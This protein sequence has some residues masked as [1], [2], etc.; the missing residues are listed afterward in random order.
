LRNAIERAVILG[1]QPQIA[2]ADLP[3]EVRQSA[4]PGGPLNPSGNGGAI[5]LEQ[6]EEQHIRRVL[7]QTR[8]VAEAAEVLGIDQATVYRKMKRLGLG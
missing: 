7:A 3:A 6:L 1:R 2:L 4:S 8:T 5:T